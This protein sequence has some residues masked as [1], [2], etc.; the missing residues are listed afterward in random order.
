MRTRSI[1]ALC[2]V[3]AATAGACGAPHAHPPPAPGGT[4][5]GHDHGDHEHG[6]HEQGGHDHGSSEGQTGHD[7]G[8]GDGHGDHHHGPVATSTPLQASTMLAELEATGIP[9][10]KLQPL[11]KMSLEEKKK[12]MPLFQKALGFKDCGG[13]HVGGSD[14]FDFKTETHHK[15]IARGMWDHFVVP[16]RDAQGA[17]VF[18]DSCHAGKVEVLNRSNHED[19][20]AFMKTQYVG[21]LRRADGQDHTCATCHGKPMVPQIFVKLWGVQ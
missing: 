13:C 17:N 3:A 18:C 1:L 19:L 11:A 2:V 16:L 10:S 21:Q 20:M 5:A 14:G 12:L 6:A 4:I 8:H 7:H 15:K 9:L